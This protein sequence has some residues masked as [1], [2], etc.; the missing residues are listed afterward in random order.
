MYAYTTTYCLCYFILL[1]LS[2][3]NNNDK[4]GVGVAIINAKP[5]SADDYNQT[6][7]YVDFGEQIEK[8]EDTNTT[9]TNT[10]T[11]EEDVDFEEVEEDEEEEEKVNPYLI[12]KDIIDDPFNLPVEPTLFEYD[13]NR[14][15]GQWNFILE[16]PIS[17]EVV[18]DVQEKTDAAKT[19]IEIRLYDRGCLYNNG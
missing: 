5:A 14:K 13:L 4:I 12:Y 9:T 2:S 3:T 18:Q 10:T 7:D 15:G 19:S 11:E 17:S 6:T 16:Y 8:D 1:L